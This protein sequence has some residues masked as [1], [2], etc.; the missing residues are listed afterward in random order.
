MLL[1]FTG[2]VCP[3]NYFEHS[4]DFK[5]R[6]HFTYMTFGT[7]DDAVCALRG[8]KG[9]CKKANGKKKFWLTYY[10][11]YGEFHITKFDRFSRMSSEFAPSYDSSSYSSSSSSR[12]GKK[13]GKKDEGEVSGSSTSTSLVEQYFAVRAIYFKVRGVSEI[14]ITC[15]GDI[16]KEVNT[17]IV[18]SQSI[19]HDFY[20]KMRTLMH[21][22]YM[23]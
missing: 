7:Q 20:R 17:D 15:A 2:Y 4:L 3:E 8:N 19:Q 10:Y 18:S 13:K 5:N 11:G 23:L 22:L 12:K 1:I 9:I 6:Q 14:V 21:I 16:S